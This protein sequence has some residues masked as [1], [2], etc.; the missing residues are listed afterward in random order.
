MADGIS[1]LGIQLQ[2]NRL[3]QGSAS[4]L[5]KLSEQLATGVK[6]SNLYDYSTSDA[7]KLLD[8]RNSITRHES[9]VSA[10]K[11]VKPRMELYDKTLAGMSDTAN[12]MLA[13]INNT[14]NYTAAQNGAVAEQI[15]GFVNQ[16]EGYLNV[17]IGDRYLYSSE[18]YGTSP[19]GDIL[20]LALP[21]AET[22]PVTTPTLPPWD[23]ERIGGTATNVSGW[24]QLSTTID[25]SLSVTYGIRNVEA[26]IQELVQGLRWAYAATQDQANFDTYMANARSE[27]ASALPDLRQLQSR[28]ASNT[29]TLDQTREL[30]E[31][32]ISDIKDNIQDIQ[33]VDI[34][35]VATKVS[36]YQTQL[37]ASYAVTAQLASLTI[38]GYFR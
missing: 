22:Y 12:Q 25:D 30:H 37:Q 17:K 2:S 4:I 5:S 21:P 7:R 20:S 29:S 15:A 26:G 6:S 8:F 36:F 18:R 27:L 33:Y 3:I 9:Y 19:A 13:L 32:V 28:V 35:E 1:S 38:L 11:A 31:K 23:S 34:N 14:Q 10:I 24:T 16:V